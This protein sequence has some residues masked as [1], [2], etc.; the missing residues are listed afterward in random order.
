MRGGQT[1]TQAWTEIFQPAVAPKDNVQSTFR[2]LQCQAYMHRQVDQAATLNAIGPS[3][4]TIF[5]ARVD[6]YAAHTSNRQHLVK[7]LLT[8]TTMAYRLPSCL[9]NNPSASKGPASPT[10]GTTF[11]SKCDRT[12]KGPA[13]PTTGLPMSFRPVAHCS[14]FVMESL[15]FFGTQNV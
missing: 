15:K 13:S 9:T 6:K 10:T 1:R 7:C 11:P 5:V 12:V 2:R 3:T 8:T 14:I 4:Q